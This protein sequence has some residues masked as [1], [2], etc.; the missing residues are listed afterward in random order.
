MPVLVAK[1]DEHVRGRRS[2]REGRKGR[3]TG[4]LRLKHAQTPAL[5]GDESCEEVQDLRR[6][7]RVGIH[8]VCLIGQSQAPS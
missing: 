5:P 4:E 3:H 1:V 7:D 2:N 6:V 8:S